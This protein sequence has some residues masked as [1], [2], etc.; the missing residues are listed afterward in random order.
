MML[1]ANGIRML[2]T[3]STATDALE[4]PEQAAADEIEAAGSEPVKKQ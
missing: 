3:A 4:A 2:R 1:M